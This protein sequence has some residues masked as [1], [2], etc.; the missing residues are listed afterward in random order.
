M[1]AGL[2]SFV[3]LGAPQALGAAESEYPGGVG[4][5]RGC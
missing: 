1:E 2:L 3:S 5:G 4:G